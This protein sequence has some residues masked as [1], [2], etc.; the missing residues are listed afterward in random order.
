MNLS[1][2]IK[3]TESYRKKI[4]IYLIHKQTGKVSTVVCFHE[5]EIVLAIMNR[6]PDFSYLSND[7]G[8]L[9]KVTPLPP[10]DKGE[11]A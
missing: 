8:L 6:G 3:T 11:T 5:Y 7:A 4:Q 1:D 10:T 2:Y 9:I